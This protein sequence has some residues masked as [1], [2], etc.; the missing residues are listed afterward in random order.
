M[1]NF[2]RFS[3][4]VVYI[5]PAAFLQFSRFVGGK[6][7][8]I[9]IISWGFLVFSCLSHSIFLGFWGMFFSLYRLNFL[10]FLI[11]FSLLV[12]WAAGRAA[13]GCAVF[14]TCRSVRVVR[15]Q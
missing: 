12:V 6:F 13:G 11:C 10:V 5:L 4:L 14:F 1:S 3:G 8:C 2:R 9:G 7:G 15:R